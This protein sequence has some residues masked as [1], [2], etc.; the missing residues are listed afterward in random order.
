M[1]PER[2]ISHVSPRHLASFTATARA[3][4]NCDRF[5]ITHGRGPLSLSSMTGVPTGP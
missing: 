2:G 1:T 3:G 5:T 4:P